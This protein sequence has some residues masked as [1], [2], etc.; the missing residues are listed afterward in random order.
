MLPLKLIKL[1]LLR[2]RSEEDYRAMQTY[3][4]EITIQELASRGVDFAKAH[5]LELAAGLGGYSRVLNKVSKSFIASDIKKDK[6]FDRLGIPF[7]EVDVS[8]TFPFKENSFF[9]FYLLQ[10]PHRTSKS[11]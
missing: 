11:T 8:K 6:L 10:Q 9:R 4:A 3:I 7:Q 1:G 2:S 5:V